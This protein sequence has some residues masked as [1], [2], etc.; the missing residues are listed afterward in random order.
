MDQC[1]DNKIMNSN[2]LL[3]H[4]VTR[5][6]SKDGYA[7]LRGAHCEHVNNSTS[8]LSPLC[9]TN[10]VTYEGNQRNTGKRFGKRGEVSRVLKSMHEISAYGGHHNQQSTVPSR[11]SGHHCPHAQVTGLTR[12]RISEPAFIWLGR[13]LTSRPLGRMCARTG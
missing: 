5:T 11:L 8:G 12:N 9:R 13:G 3:C 7:E 1:F 4:E 2:H 10:P 6:Q